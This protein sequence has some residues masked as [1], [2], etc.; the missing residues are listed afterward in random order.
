MGLPFLI[1]LLPLLDAHIAAVESGRSP[2]RAARTTLV[3]TVVLGALAKPS[4]LV[5]LVPVLPFYLLLVRRGSRRVLVST[6]LLVLIPAAAVMGWQTWYLGSKQSP[7]FNSGWTFDPIVQPAF[8]WH[9]AGPVFWIPL[10]VVLW[11]LVV[12]RGRFLRE[13]S[14]QLVL[15]CMVVALPLMLCVRETG[16]KAADGNMAVP[17]QACTTL[18]V[19]LALRT[20]VRSVQRRWRSAGGRSRA[21]P[22]LVISAGLAL[23]FLA[24]GALSYLDA[25]QVVQVPTDWQT[26][27]RP[28]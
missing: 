23:L 8:G 14:V 7:E 13:S 22:S 9:R 15:S 28:R 11:A 12:T 16:V 3:V 26:V 18:L 10:I 6:T 17:M 27:A 19:L 4:F 24:G 25:V 21:T 1:L 20:C 2:S 5:C